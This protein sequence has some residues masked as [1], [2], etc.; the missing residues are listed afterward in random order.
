MKKLFTLTS[1]FIYPLLFAQINT[2]NGTVGTTVNP[3]NGNIGIGLTNPTKKLE[4]IGDLKSTKAEFSGKELNNEIFSSW[5][6][7]V[8]K[9]IVLSAGTSL[10]NFPARRVFNMLDISMLSPYNI[11][12]ISFNI[13]DRLGKERMSFNAIEGSATEYTL[14]DQQR[15]EFF[16]VKDYGDSKGA[17]LQ[18]GKPNTKVIIGGFSNDPI[19][20]DRKFVVKG[21]SL[22]QGKVGIGGSENNPFGNFP[23]SVGTTNVTNYNLFVKG[24]ILAEEVRVNLQSAWADYVFKKEYK[25]PTLNEVENHIIDKG[26]LINV[27]S[28]EFIKNNGLELGEMTK[29]QQ[30]KIEELTLYLIQQ[31]KMIE[32]QSKMIEELY[33]RINALESKLNSK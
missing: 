25:L 15:S 22:I 13:N 10:P 27:P 5:D 33:K 3:S 28:A 19:I 4:V 18:M 30:E 1:I 6:D 20:G 17:Y 21:N 24:G 11:R 16:K 2:P 7:A 23:T 8:D 26:C 12:F 9:S 31:N 29:I 14:F 32:N